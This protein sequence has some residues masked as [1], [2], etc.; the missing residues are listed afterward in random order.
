MENT[1]QLKKSIGF[2]TATSIVVGIVIGSGVFVKP[3][4]V[5]KQAG[6]STAALL[7]WV[8]GGVMTIAA[9]LTIAEVASRIPKTGGIYSYIEEVYGERLGFLAGWVLTFLYGP[10]LMG[11]LSLYFAV[12]L[13]PFFG[14]EADLIKTVALATL[15]FLAMMNILGVKYGGYIQTATA[16]IKLIPIFLILV[17]GLTSG[18]NDIFSALNVDPVAVSFG[19]AVLS[20]LWAYDGWILV[21]NVAGE[22]KDAK[23]ILPKAIIIGLSVVLVAYLGVN[24]AMLKVLSA[25]KIVELNTGAAGVA[26]EVLFG[27]WGGKLLSIGI[28]VSIF[29]CL[30]GAVLSSPRV[31]YAVSTKGDIKGCSWLGKVHPSFKTPMNA[32]L[33]QV[34]VAIAMIMLASPDQITDFAIFSVYIFYTLAFFS[35]FIL[36]K[37]Q[38]AHDGYRTPLYPVIP[39]IAVVSALYILGNTVIMQTKIALISIVITAFG[40]PIYLL[41]K[42]KKEV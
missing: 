42:K 6:S 39:L 3:G 34:F 31:P 38:P 4:L 8:L 7:A 28:L 24:T 32:I 22:M 19:S 36:R 29:G 25:D 10:G 2:W 21:G 13:Q 15:S 35:I 1:S 17:V 11:A 5:L 9:G 20:T 40:L 41:L 26:A 37:K 27:S 23:R 16:G 14:Y 30:N 33:L 12:L 18:E